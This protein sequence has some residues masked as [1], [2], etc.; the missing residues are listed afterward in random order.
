MKWIEKVSQKLFLAFVF[1][2]PWQTIFITRELFV[3]G[4]KWQYA[5]IGMYATE[6]IFWLAILL[7]AMTKLPSFLSSTKKFSIKKIRSVLSY[8]PF[9]GVAIAS[10]VLQLVIIFLY[11]RN[12]YSADYWLAIQ[13]ILYFQQGLLLVMYL[14]V[15]NISQK[16]FINTLLAGAVL[17]VIIGVMQFFSQSTIELSLLGLSKHEVL[18][19]G[20]SV[21]VTDLG[22]RVMRAYGSFAHPNILGGYIVT[23]L[24]LFALLIKQKD[25]TQYLSHIVILSLG[26]F[27][28]FSRSAWI[29]VATLFLL[30]SLKAKTGK[31]VTS[32]FVISASV[33][34]V[35]AMF[36][37]DLLKT[38][39]QFS[40]SSHESASINERVIGAQ[41]SFVIIEENFIAGVGVGQYTHALQMYVPYRQI[42]EYQ[43]VHNVFLLLVSEQGIFVLLVL[44]LVIRQMVKGAANMS[45]VLGF[46]SIVAIGVL[47]PLFI[48]DHYVYSTYSGV[49][50]VALVIGGVMIKHRERILGTFV[51]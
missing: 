41:E 21:V 44:L 20:T 26:L 48:F 29:A 37:F 36:N 49:M 28:S 18:V 25:Y 24:F 7:F 31:V 38:R 8:H 45:V 9:T 11:I 14:L 30:H 40:H 4:V 2:L 13:Q 3:D 43:P 1:L 51:E 6:V 35:L 46:D 16:K 27:V 19:P 12:S 42:W 33:F 23:L 39:S 34:I 10:L 32:M 22:K 47:L 17:P 5:T 50:F 15:S